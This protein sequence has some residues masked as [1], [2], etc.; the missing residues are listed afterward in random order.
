MNNLF[1]LWLSLSL[2]GSLVIAVFV[3]LKPLLLRLSKTWQYYAWLLVVLRLLIP[4]SPHTSLV[5]S[6]FNQVETYFTSQATPVHAT[7]DY[8]ASEVLQAPVT[9][10]PEDV[11]TKEAPRVATIFDS[12]QNHIWGMLWLV[13]AMALLARKA[14]GYARFLQAVKEQ[15]KIITDEQVSAALHTV[16][17]EMGLRREIPVCTNPLVRAPMLVGGIRPLI[18]L[19][20]KAIPPAELMFIFRHELTHYRRK[21]F[22]YKW[23][24]ELTVCLHWFNPF[25]YWVKKQVNQDCEFSCDEW[26]VLH[27]EHQERQTYGETLLNAIVIKNETNADLVSL[28]LGE[29]GRLIQERLNAIMQYHRKSKSI[30][31]AAAMLTAVLLCGTVFAGAYTKTAIEDVKTSAVAAPIRIQNNGIEPGG[32]ISLG[33]QPLVSGT[34]CMVS[35]KWTGNGTLTVLCTSSSG[36][37]KT[38]TAANGKVTTFQVDVSSEYTIAV[39]NNTQGRM[40]NV[41]GS[42]SFHPSATNLQPQNADSSVQPSASSTQ[43]IVYENVEMRHYEEA[44]GHP[45]IHDTKT[46]ATTKAITGFQYGMLAFDGDGNPLKINWW[47]LDTKAKSTYFYLDESPRQISPGKTYDVRGGWSLNILGT[48]ASVKQI[49][50]VLYCDKEITFADGTIWTN[51]DFENWRSTYEGKK[52]DTAILQNY[53]PYEQKITF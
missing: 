25:V 21:D 36:A 28:S 43:R 51:P 17:S 45:Y 49:A 15:S 35:L 11:S 18:V 23:L 20:A 16:C 10:Y 6:F 7:S 5:G 30:V 8:P 34:Q 39:K 29:D 52:T 24:T 46:N 13:L 26:V 12:V 14:F 50:Y 3:V 9:P 47:S 4:L 19:P 27:L 33:A 1:M 37:E 40:S 48:D 2:S 22:F 42:I 31:F 41:S 53:Y 38:Y 32:K 44:D